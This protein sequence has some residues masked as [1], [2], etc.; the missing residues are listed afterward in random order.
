MFGNKGVI[1]TGFFDKFPWLAWDI[2]LY[3]LTGIV[4]AEVVFTFPPAFMREAAIRIVA[5]WQPRDLKAVKSLIDSGALSL[6]DLIT[7]RAPASAAGD[8]YPTAFTDPNCLKM[9]LDWRNV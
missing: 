1:T 9:V 5:E 4:I 7:H 2:H 6:A 3:G 8:A